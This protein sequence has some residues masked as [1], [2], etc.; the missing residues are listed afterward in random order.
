MNI[1]IVQNEDTTTD[2]TRRDTT[3]RDTTR[4]D[5]TRRDATRRDAS[6]MTFFIVGV[7]GL[8]ISIFLIVDAWGRPPWH[9]LS[10]VF[11]DPT[12]RTALVTLGNYLDTVD[13]VDTNVETAGIYLD[14]VDTGQ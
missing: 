9:F 5:T 13:T 3:R 6:T 10:W 14:T 1:K 4:H 7:E 12:G 2:A 8:D 11:K